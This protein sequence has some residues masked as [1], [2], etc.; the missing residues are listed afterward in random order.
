MQL[1]FGE[2]VR[3]KRNDYLCYM[4]YP[5]LRSLLFT[6]SPEQA[7]HFSMKCLSMACA[8][9]GGESLITSC[10][11]YPSPTPKTVSGVEFPNPIG[12]GAGFDKNAQY[13]TALK[14]L[15]FGF[16][17]VGTITPLAQPGND[18]P[19]LFRL[20]ADEA[21][22]NRM[23]FNNDGMEAVK[24]RL[25]QWKNREAIH[26]THRMVVG[27]NLGKNKITPNEDAWKDYLK[28][29]Q[30]LH[31]VADYFVVNV[32]SP[33]TP[34][35]RELQDKDA[36]LQIT[37]RLQEYNLG[38]QNPKPIWLKIAPDLSKEQLNDIVELANRV[39]LNGLVATNTTI[40][41]ENLSQ[42]S[43]EKLSNI[44]MG[45]LSGKPLQPLS[46]EVFH[47]LKQQC[48]NSIPIISSGGIMSGADGAARLLAGAD[49]IQI[50]T[51]F[52]YRGPSLVK[53]IGKELA[54]HL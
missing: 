16:V 11:R 3:G 50:W 47:Y 27:A 4:I 32:S 45:G 33:N 25:A 26:T 31:D 43:Q 10:F 42:T 18:K 34:G 6:L 22:I 37:G 13:L 14:A 29:F 20:P 51:G 19:R 53:Q 24:L 9:P 5:L 36:L 54:S 8:I 2:V 35:L 38:K 30:H 39:P 7:H 44:G 48:G 49:L 21:L 28:V 1:L 23:G 40:S 17:E 15:G 12:L 46:Q 41:R 52:I